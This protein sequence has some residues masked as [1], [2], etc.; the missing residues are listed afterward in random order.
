M[1][2]WS[3]PAKLDIAKN[4]GVGS[5][6]GQSSFDPWRCFLKIAIIGGSGKMGK[7]FA[8]FLLK[9]GFEVTITGRDEAKLAA[10]QKELG[11]RAA[12]NIE[13]VQDADAILL[14]V[15]IDNFEE[16]VQEIAPLVKPEQVIV[17]ITSIKE[18]PVGFMHLYFDQS[19]V[20]GT[21]PVFGPGA[22][23]VASQNFVLTPTNEKEMALAEKVKGYLETR[24]ARVTLMN[25]DEHD[26]MMTVVLGLAHFISIVTADTLATL[27]SLPQMKAIG[28]S[29]YRVLTTL[30]ESVISEDPELYATLQ[31]HLPG[32]AYVEGLF[33][34]NA[35]KWADFVTN[36]D[37]PSFKETMTALKQKFAEN[38]SNFG[39]AYENMY[40]IMEWL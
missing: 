32:L 28:G 19:T 17:D 9:E 1:S 22:K 12:T 14:S 6:F 37:K 36:Q 3:V 11:V 25:P 16:A 29:T 13:A 5:I 30:V 15:N 10:V 38:N 24:G 4:L 27:D 23:D 31:M 26:R 7:W 18:S 33:Q 35:A 8:S 34:K 2:F 40:K 20:L 39:Q 21:H